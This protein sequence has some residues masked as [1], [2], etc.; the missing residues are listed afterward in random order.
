MREGSNNKGGRNMKV[1]TAGQMEQVIEGSV[2][3]TTAV[4]V[5]SETE[6][7]MVKKH[8]ETKEAN[9]YLGAIKRQKKN[10]MIGFDYG[11]SV[12][13][14]AEREGKDERDAKSRTW[15]VLSESRLFVHH[16]GNSYL[17]LKLQ[18]VTDTVYLLDGREIPEAD[19]KPYLSASSKS[20]TQA[21]LDKQVV[22]NDI[23]MANINA[24]TM[25]GET[26]VLSHGASEQ[27]KETTSGAT[28]VPA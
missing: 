10:G 9:P 12:N 28:V 11:N 5:V 18:S 19:I 16:K 2:K 22:V 1:V 8:R 14:Q 6:V 21:D 13:N 25:Q 26:Y 24:I 3:G 17:Q 4:S 7:R 20:S 15:G 27:E 23:K